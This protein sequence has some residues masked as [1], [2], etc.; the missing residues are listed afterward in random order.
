MG[1]YLRYLIT[2]D[3]SIS[4]DQLQTGLKG[5]DPAYSVTTDGETSYGKD[6]CGDIDLNYPHDGLF[7]EEIAELKDEISSL[8]KSA[9]KDKVL[10][11]L[12]RTNT[13]I[14]VQVL[15][16]GRPTEQTLAMLNPLWT[17]LFANYEGVL[18]ADVEGYYSVDKPLLL[19]EA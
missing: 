3:K 19:F 4:L 12:D 9:P 6:L 18:Y 8:P 15:W 14:A 11:I 2:D 10:D 16:Q 1:Y 7:D 5:V 13:I 17:W